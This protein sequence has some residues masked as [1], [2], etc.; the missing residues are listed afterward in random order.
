M[1]YRWKYSQSDY[2]T[3]RVLTVTD[4]A[5]EIIAQFDPFWEGGGVPVDPK[6]REAELVQQAQR[7]ILAHR[8]GLAQLADPATLAEAAESEARF[9]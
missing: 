2:G 6:R 4:S 5:G 7:A 8:A 9:A 1:A 3:E